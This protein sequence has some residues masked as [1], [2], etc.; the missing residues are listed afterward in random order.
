[1]ATTF[2]QYSLDSSRPVFQSYIMGRSF[3]PVHFPI[4]KVIK[5]L[6][7]WLLGNL[8]SLSFIAYFLE[9]FILL[10]FYLLQSL[11]SSKQTRSQAR[12]QDVITPTPRAP[13][14]GTP[15]VPQLGAHLD[16]GPNLE[17]AAP[18]MKEVRGP[19]RSSPF[20]GVVGGFPGIL[21]TA[22]KGPGEDGEEEEE[23]FVEEEDSNGTEGVPAP[24]WA[25]QGT[26]GPTL[27][28]SN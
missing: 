2:I 6:L 7:H 10:L 16:R 8:A 1:M 18:S 3:N 27:A 22:F 4:W 17:G 23:N 19:R 20:S 9:K 15:A 5:D 12:A 24:V 13:L 26:L 25:S 14:D 11:E 21:R 28:Q